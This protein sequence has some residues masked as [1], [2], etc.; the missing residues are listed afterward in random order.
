MLRRPRSMFL[1]LHSFEWY[2][3]GLGF[4]ALGLEA[5]LPIPQAL[6][7][8]ERKVRSAVPICRGLSGG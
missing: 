2:V 8:F 1:V 4:V 7:N 5:T 3:T 6:I